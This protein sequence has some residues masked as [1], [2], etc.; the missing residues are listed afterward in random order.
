M[1]ILSDYVLANM[2]CNKGTFLF[3]KERFPLC[4]AAS[5]E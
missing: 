1:A 3:T 2:S 4:Q 5:N